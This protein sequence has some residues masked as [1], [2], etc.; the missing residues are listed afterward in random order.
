MSLS[1][2]GD[3]SVYAALEERYAELDK[4]NAEMD[5]EGEELD[6]DLRRLLRPGA[7][8][9]AAAEPSNANAGRISQAQADLRSSGEGL[10][11]GLGLRAS[12]EVDMRPAAERFEFPTEAA[13][14][15]EF[16]AAETRSRR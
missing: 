14:Q 5:K 9:A 6:E 2:T 7:A 10:A 12:R 16:L 11:S 4:L 1:G 15:E 8:A 13:P 3:L